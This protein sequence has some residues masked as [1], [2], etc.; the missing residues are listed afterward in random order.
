MDPMTEIPLWLQ[1]VALGLVQGLTEFLPVSSSGH[2]VIAPY[3]F[4]WQ[5]PSLAFGVALHVGTLV[6]VIAYF[7]SDLVFLARG[8]LGVGGLGDDDRRLARRTTVL[9]ALASLPAAVLGL[10]LGSFFDELFTDPRSAAFA[11]FVT[12]ALLLLAERL[13]ARRAAA[14]LEE[15]REVTPADDVGRHEGTVTPLDAVVIGAAQ[16]LAL[17]PGISRAGATMAT[18]MLR[19]LSRTAAARFS[20]LMSIPVIAGA[21]LLEVPALFDAEG[22][23]QF[24]LLETGVATLAAAASGFWA[25]RYLLRLVATDDLRGFARYVLLLGLVTLSASLWLGPPGSA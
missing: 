13:R 20:F 1:A 9:L 5:Q 15:D 3:L 14:A 8:V 25:I 17:V 11:L 21:G 23:G 19:G 7:R 10:S 2:L 16:A 22:F 12:A 4:D 6:A 18:G 24:T